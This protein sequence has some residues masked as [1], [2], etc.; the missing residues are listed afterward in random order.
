MVP[1][2]DKGDL[3]IKGCPLITLCRPFALFFH[4]RQFFYY[5][6]SLLLLPFTESGK[7][8]LQGLFPFLDPFIF[9][10]FIPVHFRCGNLEGKAVHDQ[11]TA[12]FPFQCLTAEILPHRACYLS[13]I[14]PPGALLFIRYPEF[15]EVVPGNFPLFHIV[16][17][18][19]QT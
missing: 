18:E 11:E 19:R 14:I 6:P 5:F 10:P 2:K 16:F 4:L 12:D 1:L 8:G 13:F 7:P 3:R 15:Q 17:G 9:P